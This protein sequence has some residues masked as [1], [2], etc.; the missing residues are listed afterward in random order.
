MWVLIETSLHYALPY[1][2]AGLVFALNYL[3]CV[4]FDHFLQAYYVDVRHR[5]K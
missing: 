3:F 5:S 1:G 4:E 2:C